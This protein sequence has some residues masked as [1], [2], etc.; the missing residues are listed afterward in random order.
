MKATREHEELALGVSPRGSIALY[1]AAQAQA[2]LE[3]LDFVTPHHVKTLAGP[4]CSHR[5][6]P[7]RRFGTE[8]SSGERS[9]RVIDE[10]LQTVE[11]P[12]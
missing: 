3:G 6:M 2:L 4:V 12:L 9:R 10:I 11:V 5:V 8:S 7:D 1:R